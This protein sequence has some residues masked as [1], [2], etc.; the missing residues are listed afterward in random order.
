MNIKQTLEICELIKINGGT[1]YLVGGAVRDLY[2]TC[3]MKHPLPKDW[4]M[5]VYGLTPYTLERILQ[6]Y[7]VKFVGKSFG[8]YKL[9]NLD[10]SFPRVE[11]TTG[12]GHRDFEV[13]VDPNMSY[14]EACKR[15]DLTMNAILFNPL[16]KEFTDP[17]N[18]RQDITDKVIRHVNDET[19]A[20]DP[21]RVLRVIQFAARFGFSINCQT[22]DLCVS[23]IPKLRFLSKER[24]FTE[25]K[26]ILLKAPKP[27]VGFN[28]ML[29]M[30]ILQELFPEIDKLIT[31][32]ETPKYHPE[33][34]T[35]THTMLALDS[36]P[37]GKRNLTVMLA[38]LLHDVGK[39]CVPVKHDKGEYHY[40]G[41][42][43]DGLHTIENIL[44]RLTDEKKLI[45]NVLK[46]VEHH[47]IQ[48]PLKRKTIR[49]LS[50]KLNFEQLMALHR[51][52]MVGRDK[53]VDVSYI[54]N[55][56]QIYEDI[57]NTIKP[58]ITGKH[59]IHEFDLTPSPLFGK[60]LRKVYDAQL[61]EE[62][63]TVSDGLKYTEKIIQEV[64]MS[65]EVNIGKGTLTYRKTCKECNGTGLYEH[66]VY[67]KKITKALE[68]CRFCYGSGY[69]L[70]EIEIE[71]GTLEL[72]D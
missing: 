21:L 50:L 40:Y 9:D 29:N 47:M 52:D 20:E 56:L 31:L 44:R 18:G 69:I 24:I 49:R 19:F 65:K 35:Y 71:G 42:Q 17:F 4:D 48:K 41:H 38:I 27:S 2:A 14:Y 70:T 16:T 1:A 25:I 10:I 33:G 23:L 64:K 11:R 68:N 39:G 43:S 15:R 58:I 30:G 28:W 22:Y 57:K 32:R 8:V 66:M 60:V 26:K 6:H 62:F 5:E 45:E 63:S 55:Y 13:T 34:D 3:V 51:A 54:E 46:L 7:S 72:S 36:V 12:E 53:E 61:N 67:A 59:L 37:L